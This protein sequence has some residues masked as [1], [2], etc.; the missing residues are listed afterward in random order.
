[1][2]RRART[3]REDRLREDADTSHGV[4]CLVKVALAHSARGSREAKLTSDRQGLARSG[5][6]NPTDTIGRAALSLFEIR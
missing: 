3:P 6:G 4:G 2:R 1:V 5:E